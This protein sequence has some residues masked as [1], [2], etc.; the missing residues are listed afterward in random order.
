MAGSSDPESGIGTAELLDIQ[1]VPEESKA[2]FLI[3]DDYGMGGI[4]GYVLARS[5]EEAAARLGGRVGPDPRPRRHE[6]R[7]AGD[8]IIVFL[9]RPD[10]MDDAHENQYTGQRTLDLDNPD[11][12]NYFARFL[13]DAN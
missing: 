4:W 2:R 10:W 7:P 8:G 9:E 6:G 13:V 1:P 3:V 11:P 12:S 5:A